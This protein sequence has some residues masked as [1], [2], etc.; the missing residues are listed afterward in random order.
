MKWLDLHTDFK[1]GLLDGGTTPWDQETDDYGFGHWKV[2]WTRLPMGSII[3]QDVFQCKLDAIFLSV[4]GIT[5]ITDDMIIF[6]K[7]D[8]K[9]NG[10]LLNFLEVCRENNLTLQPWEDAVQTSQSFLLWPHL[11]WQR[12]FSRSKENWSSEENGNAPRCGNY[13]KLPRIDQLPQLF[14]S[15]ASWVKQPTK[16]NLQT[17]SGIPAYKS[18]WDCLSTL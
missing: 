9:H 2:Q 11:E 14:L 3:A 15:K 6:R 13:E 5:G 4:P 10:D 12:S 1:Q 18:L 16:G 8:Q 7:T 17:E